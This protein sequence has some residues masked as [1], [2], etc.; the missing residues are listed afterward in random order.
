[1]NANRIEVAHSTL[2]LA[3]MLAIAILVVAPTLANALIAGLGNSI[4]TDSARHNSILSVQALN[5]LQLWEGLNKEL[6]PNGALVIDPN[7]YEIVL[8]SELGSR[9]VVSL[10]RG[11]MKF[12]EGR[13]ILAWSGIHLLGV[14][15]ITDEMWGRF[16]DWVVD[17]GLPRPPNIE[18]SYDVQL[19][20]GQMVI[21]IREDWSGDVVTLARESEYTTTIRHLYDKDVLVSP[22]ID[23]AFNRFLDEHHPRLNEA[24]RRIKRDIFARLYG[25]L[26]SRR[27]VWLCQTQGLPIDSY[28]RDYGIVS[29]S[30]EL[31][32]D[33]RESM[34]IL[35]DDDV[36]QAGE[37]LGVAAA[38]IFYYGSTLFHVGVP[39]DLQLGD[40]SATKLIGWIEAYV[41]PSSLAKK[42]GRMIPDELNDLMGS[43]LQPSDP[44]YYTHFIHHPSHAQTGVSLGDAGDSIGASKSP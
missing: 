4:P 17:R 16:Q 22:K 13:R 44:G 6:A 19:A 36:R 30:A 24:E 10:M 18:P 37:E 2:T 14:A 26:R 3:G 11:L 8:R 32:G 25:N 41:D 35:F 15:F 12:P 34:A 20:S 31:V 9:S 5:N 29:T 38:D 21:M 7:G 1:M 27:T 23:L 39:E 40:G 28:Y 33:F 42:I 43:V